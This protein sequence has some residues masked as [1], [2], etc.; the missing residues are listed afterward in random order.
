MADPF[1]PNRPSDLDPTV[2]AYIDRAVNR[3]LRDPVGRRDFALLADGAI[4]LPELTKLVT[5]KGVTDLP[6]GSCPDAALNDDMRIGNCWLVS[7]SAVQLGLRLSNMIHPTHVSID[8]I[9]FEI[10][11][12]IGRAPCSMLLWGGVDGETNQAHLRNLEPSHHVHA[13]HAR[14]RTGPKATRGYDFVLLG[15]FEYDIRA[16]SHVQTFTLEPEFAEAGMYFGVVVLEITSNW[17]A[18]STCLYRFRIHGDAYA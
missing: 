12:D 4:V 14:G 5:P 2:K 3:V 10:A 7:G 13:R 6:S 8:H 16:S 18:D 9:P 11:T 1:S 17:G 15:S